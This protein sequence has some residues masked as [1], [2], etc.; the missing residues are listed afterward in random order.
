MTHLSLSLLGHPQI[1]VDGKPAAGFDSNKVR[2]LLIYLAAEAGRPHSREI[3][4]EMLWPGLPQGSALGNLRFALSNLRATIG[5]RTAQPPF[6]LITNETLHFNAESDFSL[7]VRAFLENT[8]TATNKLPGIERLRHAVALYRGAFMEG[9]SAGESMALEEW[10]ALKREQFSRRM[11]N[12][13][14]QLAEYYEGR[15]EYEQALQFAWRQVELEPWLEEGHQ[16]LMRVLALS[17]QRSAA[18]A[19]YETCRRILD[20]ELGVEPSEETTELYENIRKGTFKPRSFFAPPAFL[21]SDE[22]SLEAEPRLFAGREAELSRLNGFL[23]NAIARHGQVVFIAGDPGMGKTMLIQEFARRS[24]NSHANLIS[25]NGGCN[26][27]SGAGDPYLPFIGILKMLSGDVESE[28]VSGIISHDHA[29]RLWGLLPE[30]LNALLNDGQGLIDRFIPGTTLF[31]RAQLGASRQAVQLEELLKRR[32]MSPGGDNVQQ[33]D[34]FEQYTKVLF[35]LSKKRPLLLIIDDLHW[36]DAGSINLLFHLGRQIAN[37]RILIIGAFRP[38]DVALGRAGER[39]P[40]ELVI[41]ELQHVTG[42]LMVDLSQAQGRQFVEDLVDSEPNQLNKAF[43][44]TLFEHTGGNPLFTVELLRGL[45]ERGDLVKD[46]NG[47]WIE[48]PTLNWESTLPRVDAVIAERIGR[49]P[50]ALANI[51]SIASIEGETFT[52]EA[53]ALVSKAESREVI[54]QLSG[55]LNKLHRLTSIAGFERSGGS[56]QSLSRYRFRH[57]LFQKYLY[58][59]LDEV[60][61]AHLH[62]AMGTA[63]ETLHGEGAP[64]LSG[65]LARHFEMAGIPRKAIYY[66]LQAGDNAAHLTANA[67]A[68]THYR[69]GLELLKTL[70][71]LP[72][73]MRQ[74]L[75][76]QMSLG[77]PITALKGYSDPEMGQAYARAYELCQQMGM[78]PQ[79][80]PVLTGLGGYYS[81]RAEYQTAL[82]IYREM[83]RVAEGSGDPLLISIAHWGMGYILVG[84]GDFAAGRIYLERA[85]S[86]YKPEQHSMLV[87]TYYQDPGVSCL[88]WLSWALWALGYADQSLE[89][90]REALALAEKLSHPFSMAFASGLASGLHYFRRDAVAAQNQA[91]ATIVLASEKGFPF[92]YAIAKNIHGWGLVRQGHQEGFAELREGIS[93]LRMSGAVQPLPTNLAYLVNTLIQ[94]DQVEEGMN[95]LSEG[96]EVLDKDF[97]E[98]EL[99]R[100]KGKLLLLRGADNATEAEVCFM[101]AI[102]IARR[103]QAKSWELRAVMSLCELWQGQKKTKAAYELLFQTY[104]WFTEGFDTLDLK[105]AAS[106]LDQ[107]KIEL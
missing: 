20:K 41:N 43:R 42:D 97:S 67:E 1:T 56:G 5:D 13:L 82:E 7:D 10:I 40:L 48:G 58:N 71:D 24:M 61:Q 70:P 55:P 2:A 52:A 46:E 26:A 18:L 59:Q 30:T 73:R 83:L 104:S 23:D 94:T 19:Q 60:E 77:V 100:L 96:F 15:G 88:T 57:F 6:L 11:L 75:T 69:H 36:A 47:K 92:W 25:V 101:R 103:Q 105:E 87:S 21:R 28:W 50:K 8:E 4:A 53:I 31:S 54:R 80:I 91:E 33:N 14:R 84:T 34:L 16:L 62:E 68:I 79:L 37:E 99:H 39:H 89:R 81:L 95:T 107:L 12:A 51:L 35:S 64:Q 32:S 66:L 85:L 74:E 102:E 76:L 86:V 17:G 22:D 90:S 65:Q 49:L 72:E 93:I 63:L 3:L 27:Y 78:T 45:Q 9:F 38:G 106:L 98:A 29:N 44:E